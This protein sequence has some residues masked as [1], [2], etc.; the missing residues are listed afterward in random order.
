M[1]HPDAAAVEMKLIGMCCG[2]NTTDMFAQNHLKRIM[3]KFPNLWKGVGELF[4]RYSEITMLL[5]EEANRAN[6]PAMSACFDMISDKGMPVVLHS[7]AG[8]ES[9]K[10]YAGDFEYLHEL[11][12]V[13][14]N[15]RDLNVLWNGC[16]LFERGTW[17]GYRDALEHI[18]VKYPNCYFCINWWSI[19]GCT[20]A[21]TN[22]VLVELCN[23]NPTRFMLATDAAGKFGDYSEKVKVLVDFASKLKPETKDAVLSGNAKKLFGV[24]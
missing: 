24:E 5:N 23:D 11:T 7:N 2:F 22:E 13:L 17:I 16:G 9:V 10:P 12:T 18:I 3:N 1:G 6:H 14:E 20:N 15:H 4:F 19:V 21:L 8:N